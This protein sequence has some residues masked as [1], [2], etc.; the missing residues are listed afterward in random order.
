MSS[1]IPF[2]LLATSF[3]T[4]T[5]DSREDGKQHNTTFKKDVYLSRL[6]LSHSGGPI[7]V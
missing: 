7:V 6:S 4:E 3:L 1:S 5:S 2:N